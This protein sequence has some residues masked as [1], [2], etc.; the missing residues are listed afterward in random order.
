[1]GNV[2][3][4]TSSC[5]DRKKAAF[6]EYMQQEDAKPVYHASFKGRGSYGSSVRP[7]ITTPVS[8]N[9][10][11]RPDMSPPLSSRVD[12]DEHILLSARSIAIQKKAPLF[13]DNG[14]EEFLQTEQGPPQLSAR[15]L[16]L[17]AIERMIKEDRVR[18]SSSNSETR[19]PSGG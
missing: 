11:Q 15:K 13:R 4:V 2:I 1:M 12:R 14:E 6:S 10:K 3:Y 16:D 9:S 8:N 19:T 17:N 18:A 5:W 7:N